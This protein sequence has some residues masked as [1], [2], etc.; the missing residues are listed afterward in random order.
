MADV[1]VTAMVTVAVIRARRLKAPPL[2]S[3]S[4]SSV[5]ASAGDAVLLLLPNRMALA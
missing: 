5:A 3:S 1:A 4:L 2:V